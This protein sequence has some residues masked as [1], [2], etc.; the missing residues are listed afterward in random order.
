[1]QRLLL[2]EVLLNKDCHVIGAFLGGLLGKSQTSKETLKWYGEKLDELWN[3]RKVHGTLLTLHEAVKEDNAHNIEFLLDSM[4]PGGHSNTMKN[5][6]LAKFQQE[7][8]ALHVAAQSNSLQALIVILEW[9]EAVKPTF[10]H[11]LL[12][13]QDKDIETASQRVAEGGHR[14][15]V[16]N[17]WSWDEKEQINVGNLHKKLL[18][19]QDLDGRTAWH[20]AAKSGS[21][22]ILDTLWGWAK[23]AQ[24]KHSELQNKILLGKNLKGMAA[25]HVAAQ[26]GRVEI[27][28]KLWGWAKELQL[29]PGELCNE[30]LFSKGQYELTAWQMAAEQGDVELLE[31][32]WGWVKELQLKPGEL[33]NGVSL[34]I[35]EDWRKGLAY[36]SKSRPC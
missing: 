8:T 36:C 21:I 19:A 26:T 17:L 32:L 25:W 9:A 4:K 23:E 28:D 14:K 33:S 7:K 15:V 16:K 2:N 11:S 24:I 3:K 20:K 5:I 27:L 34:S 12:H 6:L 13:S 10:T 22:E 18:L 31:K 35:G 1:L 30:V 29:K